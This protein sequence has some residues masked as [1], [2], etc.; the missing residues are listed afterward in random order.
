MTLG[1]VLL[2]DPRRGGFLLSEAARPMV[3]N[4][5]AVGEN[6]VVNKVFSQGI[7]LTTVYLPP[8]E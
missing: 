3:R 8:V 5:S 1:I 4:P 6:T 2:E 7:L